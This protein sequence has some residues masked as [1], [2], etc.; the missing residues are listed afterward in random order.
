MFARYLSLTTGP[1]PRAELCGQCL[2]LIL[3][4]DSVAPTVGR[5]PRES[6]HCVLLAER[7]IRS[8]SIPWLVADGDTDVQRS[9]P[10]PFLR[11]GMRSSTRRSGHPERRR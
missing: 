8:A 9:P 7:G 5:Q 4:A 1:R 10:P 2:T 11:D 6:Q 3:L